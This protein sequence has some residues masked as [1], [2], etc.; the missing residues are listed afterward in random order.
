MRWWVACVSLPSAPQ[1]GISLHV[2]KV[3]RRG[4]EGLRA[5]CLPYRGCGRTGR[6]L[7]AILGVSF[8]GGGR[9]RLL[10]QSY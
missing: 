3:W 4:G 7:P 6:D 10:V 9:T 2:K 1:S 8:P 5:C